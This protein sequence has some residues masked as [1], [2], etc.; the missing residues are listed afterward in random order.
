MTCLLFVPKYSIWTDF[1][2]LDWQAKSRAWADWN[3]KQWHQKGWW[4]TREREEEK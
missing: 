2:N 3:G 4:A 1:L